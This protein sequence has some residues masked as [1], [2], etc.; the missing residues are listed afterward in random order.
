MRRIT[1]R[2]K[3][4]FNTP[5][6]EGIALARALEWRPTI[7][8]RAQV[9][10]KRYQPGMA[11]RGVRARMRWHEHEDS[12]DY[13][14]S[15]ASIELAGYA[16]ALEQFLGYA[17]PPSTIGEFKPRRGRRTRAEVDYSQKIDLDLD[18]I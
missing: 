16:P 9:N 10:R 12:F 5:E 6:R 1:A 17:L 18:S 2:K 14:L 3:L 4:I 15:P 11:K 7:K 13:R 8:S